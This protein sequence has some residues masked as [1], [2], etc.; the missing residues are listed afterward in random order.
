MYQDAVVLQA[1]CIIHVHYRQKQLG[2]IA[3]CLLYIIPFS[4]EHYMLVDFFVSDA[5]NAQ[6]ERGLG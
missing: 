2:L 6:E 5:G 3:P 4:R 1:R